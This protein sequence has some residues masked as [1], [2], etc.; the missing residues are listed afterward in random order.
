[1]NNRRKV[2]WQCEHCKDIQVSD[3]HK[4]HDMNWC[5]C[6]KSAVDLEELYERS[7]GHTSHLKQ[8]EYNRE[9]KVWEEMKTLNETTIEIT[10]RGVSWNKTMETEGNPEHYISKYLKKNKYAMNLSSKYSF[11]ILETKRVGYTS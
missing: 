11:K 1:M 3:S 9:K 5:E 2:V 10:D 4:R 8:I 7:V 6:G